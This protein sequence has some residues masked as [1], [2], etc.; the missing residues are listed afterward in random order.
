[1]GRI[2]VIDDEP[3][4][5][6]LLSAILERKGFEVILADSGEKGLSLFRRE[7]PDVTILDLKM[8]E[9]DGLAVLKAL[10]AVNQEALVVIFTG[11]ASEM[12]EEVRALGGVT[13]IRKEFSFHRLGDTLKRL[14]HPQAIDRPNPS[15]Q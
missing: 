1:M 3:G 6:S 8:P 14:L 10:R 7:R 9:M 15:L 4:I 13:F 5:R 11:A 12:E 2:L